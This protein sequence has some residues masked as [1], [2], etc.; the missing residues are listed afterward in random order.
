MLRAMLVDDELPSLTWLEKRLHGLDNVVIVGTFTNPHEALDS[1]ADSQPD[2]VFLDIDMPGMNGLEMAERMIETAP[3]VHIVFVTAYNYYATEA[4]ELSAIDYVLKPV[5]TAR[6]EKTISRM[7]TRQQP[8]KELQET[9]GNVAIHCFG[10]FDVVVDQQTSGMKWRT[11]KER[12]LLAFLVHNRNEL[13]A[14]EKILDELWPETPHEQA[15]AYLHTCVYNLR[16][17]WLDL[18]YKEILEYTNGCYRLNTSGVDCDVDAFKTLMSECAQVNAETIMVCERIVKLYKGNY[19]EEDG[20]LWSI[21]I[22]EDYKEKYMKLVMKMADYYVRAGQYP[23]AASSYRQIVKLNP[24]LDHVNEMLLKVYAQMGDRLS[25]VRH[26]N[27][28]T[29]LLKDELG[30]APMQSTTLLYSQLC[31]GFIDGRLS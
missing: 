18:G 1:L 29:Q 26:Y 23:Q 11:S 5:T 14:K 4:F 17:K 28:F 8:T 30:I 19:L 3:H 31:D 27:E 2:V 21:A 6:L 7:A 10:R 22:Q 25:M 16:K 15:K 12:E 24:F 20:F 9:S 13:I